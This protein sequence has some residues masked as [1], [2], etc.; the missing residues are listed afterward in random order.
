MLN[1]NISIGIN[2][3][4][5]ILGFFLQFKFVAKFQ[6]GAD[7]KLLPNGNENFLKNLPAAEAKEYPELKVDFYIK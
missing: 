2:N 4:H 1:A 5:F 6:I 3:I 7:G